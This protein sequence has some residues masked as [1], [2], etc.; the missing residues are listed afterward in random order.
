M[1]HARYYWLFVL[2]VLRFSYTKLCLVL[3]CGIL[4][5]FSGTIYLHCQS[6]ATTSVLPGADGRENCTSCIEQNLLDSKRAQDSGQPTPSGAPAGQEVTS[7]NPPG[8]GAE[9]SESAEVKAE[10]DKAEKKSAAHRGALVPAPLPIS[11]PTVGIGMVPG[12]GYIFPFS[13]SDKVSPPSVIGVA[14]LVTNNGSRGIGV[15]AD[16][17]M[18]KNTYEITAMYAHGNVNYDVYGSGVLAAVKLPLAQ[19]GDLFRTEVLRRTWWKVFVG[20]RFWTGQ[21]FTTLTLNESQVPPP[22]V[23]LGIHNTMRAL[24]L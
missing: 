16:L 15:G 21:S 8:G 9:P 5:S 22:L 2:E 14:G 17:Y 3:I 7:S 10:A 19:S 24:G 1:Q 13:R 12:V 23:G 20:P 18:K 6:S 4:F 11:S